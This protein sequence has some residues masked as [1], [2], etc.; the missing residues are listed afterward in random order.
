MR[1]AVL[2]KQI[3]KFEEMQL[4]ADGRLQRDGVELELNPYCR[5]AVSQAV[6]LAAA[7]PGS[8]V[9]FITL[10]PPSAEDSL[11]ESIAWAMH[12]DVSADGILVTDPAFAGSDT[13]ATA[14]ALEAALARATR[15]Q[16]APFDLVLVGRNSVDADTGQVG[17]ELAQ[18][19][20]MPFLNGVRHLSINGPLV[21]ARCEHDDGWLEAEVQLPAILSCAERLID[22]AKVDDAGRAAVPA[23]RIRR[24][25]AA[26]LGAGPWGQAASPTWVGDVKLMAATRAQLRDPDA[27]LPDQVREAVKRLHERGAFRDGRRPATDAS[28]TDTHA[29]APSRPGEPLTIVVVEPDRLHDTRELLGGAARLTG[30]VLAITADQPLPSE[31]LSSWG[32]DTITNLEGAGAEED[33]ATRVA[34]LVELIQAVRV[35]RPWAILTSSTAWGREVASRIAA[36]LGAGLTGDAV[37]LERVDDRMVAW[38]P[39]FGGQLVAAIHC[40]S[41]I[42]MATVRAGVLPTLVPR[43][44]GPV[45]EIPF[46]TWGRHRVRVLARTRDD[47]L[48]VLAEAHTV[49]GLGQ[50]VPPDAYD[51]LD[52][53]CTLLDAQL[54][55][56]RKVT[57]K[58]W[59]PR[60]RQIGITGRSIAPRLFVSIGAS[61]KFNHTV[62]LRAA[63]IVLAINNN[64]QAPIFAAADVGIVGDWRE[65]VPLLVEQLRAARA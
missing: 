11:R 3:P 31:Q 50:G 10:G 62:G 35:T 9:T 65:V 1:I 6:E 54:G 30:N 24:L 29:V 49:I 45:E 20:D 34:Q 21:S 18:L 52:E 53:L 32:A 38:K 47:D 43:P 33:I 64:P 13:L 61:G 15:D 8:H 63:G 7:R 28:H 36:R 19:C 37:E 57:D 55:A 25:T 42:Q 22:P 2:V 48:D 16:G 23:D 4:G 58:G 44:S 27:P 39:A 12:H 60:A 40:S 14:R 26:D 46:P 41:E 5:R 17:P 51:D 59:M 56:T